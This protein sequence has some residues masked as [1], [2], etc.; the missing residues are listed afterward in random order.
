MSID[1]AVL[2][3]STFFPISPI[4][5]N[6]TVH[7]NTID[8]TQSEFE[9]TFFLNNHFYI[10]PNANPNFITFDGQTDTNGFQLG[11]FELIL[12]FACQDLNLSPASISTISIIE[13]RN[14]LH[15]FTLLSL[16]VVSAA[17]YDI[18]INNLF[19]NIFV[20]SAVF[21]NKNPSIKPVIIKFSFKIV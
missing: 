8:M 5:D 7:L 21:M 10:N 18:I 20:I 4:C 1:L 6:Y 15:N 12:D 2:C 14:E 13:L 9:N 11:L 3:K 19:G 16:D 17:K